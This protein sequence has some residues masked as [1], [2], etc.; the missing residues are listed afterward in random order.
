MFKQIRSM[1][2]DEKAPR[3][4]GRGKGVEMDETYMGGK[5]KGGTGRPM[6]GDKVKTA[7]VGIVERKGRIKALVSDDVKGSTLLGMV[8]EYVLP[9]ST[10]FTDELNA[11]HGISHMPNMGYSHKRINHTSKVY[12][13]GD[14]H[15]NTVEGFWSLVKNGVRG[16]YHSVG[17][18]YLQ[19][20]L[21]EYSFR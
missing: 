20:Y 21:N 9:K 7:V 10:V 11:Y 18:G 4:G 2:D 17:K 3:L 6:A 16:V 14:I 1:L 12:V 19:S 8:K 5:R 13:V 15:T